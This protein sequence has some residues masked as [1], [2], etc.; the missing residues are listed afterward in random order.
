MTELNRAT[1]RADHPRTC[2]FEGGTTDT[3]GSG[4]R[5]QHAAPLLCAFRI[6]IADDL[7]GARE[8]YRTE[9]SDIRRFLA[10]RMPSSQSTV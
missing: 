7:R 9:T 10:P 4:R 6:A 1:C 2:I 3:T 5:A 8:I